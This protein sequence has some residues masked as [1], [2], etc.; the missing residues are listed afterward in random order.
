MLF[1]LAPVALLSMVLATTTYRSVSHAIELAQ[2]EI[3][4]NYAAR[5]RIWFRGALRM[6]MAM[7][8]AAHSAGLDDRAARRRC[9]R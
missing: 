7:A 5:A 9:A 6:T 8:S 4:S 2:L 1:I 3:A